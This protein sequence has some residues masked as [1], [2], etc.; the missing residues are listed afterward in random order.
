VR[1][2][3]AL[4]R[5]RASA[6][7]PAVVLGLDVNGLGVV[8]A[9][10]RHAV[11]VVGLYSDEDRV[12]SLSRYCRAVRVE[13][14]PSAETVRVL[15]TVCPSSTHSPVLLPT[16]DAYA[17]WVNENQNVL[18]PRF[19]FHTVDCQ[20]F[21]RLN[22]KIGVAQ[23][24]REQGIDVPV[25]AHFDNLS[26]FEH[27]IGALGL[28]ILVKPVDTFRRTLPG[29][30]K[31]VLFTNASALRS[32]VGRCEDR[33]PDMVFQEVVPSGDGH[34][35]VCT[36]LLD[37][38]GELVLS[39]TGRKIRQYLPDF[40][41]TCFGVSERQEHLVQLGLRFLRAVGYRGLCTLEFARHR[42]TGRYVL[43]EANLRSYLHNQLFYDCGVNFPLAEYRSL[44]GGPLPR[45]GPQRDGIHWLDFG[46]DAASF[47][48]KLRAKE[49]DPIM[50]VRSLLRARSF[51]VFA[52]DDPLPWMYETGRFL[53]RI[54]SRIPGLT[55]APPDK[56]HN[57][58]QP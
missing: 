34:I 27:G 38:A 20:L 48:R 23:L 5:A 50:W 7:S 35:Y 57:S 58:R 51:A 26:T 1:G 24:A 52:P 28:P 21:E 4:A 47:Y 37:E 9:L 18:R 3:A 32:Y 14:I 31:N 10:G 45:A 55:P 46:R 19:R 36:L 12:G 8:R 49:I 22:S 11:P 44:T 6:A 17:H 43:L 13:A 56:F 29:G 42:Q 40:G 54:S 15:Q 41:V 2:A 39:Y 25:T 33:L 53:R 16:S 30:S